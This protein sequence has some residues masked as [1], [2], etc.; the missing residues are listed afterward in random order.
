MSCQSKYPSCECDYGYE[1]DS[2]QGCIDITDCRI[3]SILYSDKT[4]TMVWNPNTSTKTPIGVVVYS[5]SLGHGQA[6]AWDAPEYGH[7]KVWGGWGIDIP[8]LPNR[9]N[10]QNDFNS[11]ENTAAIMAAGDS[12]TY[13]AAWAA[14]N[15]SSPGTSVGDWCLPASG[16]IRSI[17]DNIDVINRGLI[18]ANKIEPTYTELYICSSTEEDK[19]SFWAG[20]SRGVYSL[21]KGRDCYARPVIEF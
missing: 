11:C 12:S 20:D 1:W 17:R 15:Y 6:L 4:C 3:G 14:H 7:G 18:S 19:Y 5:S 8:D 13:P 2:E 9:S 21:L 16:I 10:P